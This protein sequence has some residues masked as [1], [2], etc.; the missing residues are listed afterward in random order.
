M[1]YQCVQGWGPYTHTRTCCRLSACTF[2]RS[3]RHR[4][5]WLSCCTLHT[6]QARISV[7]GGYCASSM[8]FFVLLMMTISK[9][10][11]RYDT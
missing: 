3:H 2:L 10:F 1:W 7:N 6:E 8:S 11:K 9:N 4:D 5:T